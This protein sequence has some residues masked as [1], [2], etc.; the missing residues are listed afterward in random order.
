LCDLNN[1]IGWS[2]LVIHHIHIG[3]RTLQSC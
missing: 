1:I 3:C 2:I